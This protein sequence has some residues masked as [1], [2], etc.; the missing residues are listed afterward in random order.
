MAKTPPSGSKGSHA[1][2]LTGS[3]MRHVTVMALTGGIGIIAVFAV[4]L[5]NFFYISRLGEKPI[6]AAVGFAGAIG[7]FQISIGIGLT[8][9]IG[10]AV[11]TAIGRADGISGSTAPRIATTSLIV[12]AV[13]TLALG[14][15]TAAA[16]NPLLGL[17]QAT[18]E[19]KSMA[20]TYLLI[21]SPALPLMILGMCAGALLRSA[22]AAKR[23]MNVTLFG[24]LAV[25]VMDPIFIFAL[26]LGLEG[27][28]ISTVISRGMM[29]FLGLYYVHKQGL[30]GRPDF[31]QAREDMAQ[32]GRV[33]GP[34]ILTN[35]ATPVGSSYVTHSMAHFG[36]AAVAG[37][38]AI[39]RIV[40]VAFGTLFALTGAVGPIMAQNLGAGRTDRVKE[41]LRAS[42]IFMVI[43]VV[44][45]WAILASVQDLLALAFQ[46]KGVAADLLHLFCSW[47]AGTA[48]FMG[49]LFVANSA[50]NNLG[51]P[52][53]AT[54][55]NW[56]RATLG[57]IPFVHFGEQYG[58]LGVL[59]GQA[60]G[61]VVFG[62]LAIVL[63]FWTVDRLHR[64][65]MARVPVP[66]IAVP[67]GRNAASNFETDEG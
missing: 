48:I 25:A 18:G 8:I 55:M 7:F 66:I 20:A 57:T 14:L 53:Y 4:D 26:H 40:P 51:R 37:Q 42:L 59:I 22:G 34:A 28:A 52:G 39:D 5:L 21:I 63:A 64:D 61:S 36:V 44:I 1:R 56:G 58:P 31:A 32:V 6:A 10:A 27:A 46:S 65:T 11:S 30:L 60:A 33:A 41:T 45:A 29:G 19:T 15:F 13:I 62:L 3:I 54:V 24:A 38:A 50:F 23:A 49:G 35:L 12:M 67:G 43:A 2:F 9:G 16:R 47:I 17:L